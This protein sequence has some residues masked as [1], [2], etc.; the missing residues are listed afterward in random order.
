MVVVDMIDDCCC[1]VV[2][3]CRGILGSVDAA[4]TPSSRLEAEP[5]DVG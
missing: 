1:K 3:G 2:T 5:A 4:A